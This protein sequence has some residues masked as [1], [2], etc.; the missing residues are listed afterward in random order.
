MFSKISQQISFA[1]G[2]GGFQ[3]AASVMSLGVSDLVC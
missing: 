2:P 3:N 1:Y